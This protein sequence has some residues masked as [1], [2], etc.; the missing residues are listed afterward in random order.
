MNILV[1]GGAGFIGS[2][3]VDKYIELGHQVT[4]VDNLE[5]GRKE[6]L[7]PKARFIKLDILDSG[8]ENVFAE[9]AFDIVNH[10]AAQVS[11]VYSLDD[12]M[13]DAKVNILGALNVLTNC[14]KFK[15]KKVI[16][17]NS[18][19]AGCGEPRYMPLDEKHPVEPLAPYGA[20]KHTIE[21]YLHLFRQNN[22]LRYFA[23]RYMNVYG[24]RQDPFGEGGVVAIFTNKMLNNET[25][26]INGD[27]EQTRDFVYVGDVVAA[28]VMALDRGEGEGVLIGSEVET[29]VNDIYANLRDLTDYQGE[30]VS[31]PEIPGEVRKIYATCERAFQVLGWRSQT[32]LAEG[33]KKTV[34]FYKD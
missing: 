13:R 25:P 24:P 3:I 17:A 34:G 32:S 23:L 2:H 29:S 4:V 7:N 20:S 16:Y 5:R 10:H 22:G 27:G 31:G 18:G 30:V 33:L 1:T 11:V 6:N 9:G 15:I 8:L 19:G 12:P 21:H 14:L 26:R 28:N